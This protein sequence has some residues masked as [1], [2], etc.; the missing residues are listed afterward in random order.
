MGGWG[1][2]RLFIISLF[3]VQQTTNGI[4]TLY[5]VVQYFFRVDDQY[6]E[7]EK[8]QQT[9]FS[10]LLSLQLKKLR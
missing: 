6:A 10:V 2:A 1:A 9:T 4:S 3:P 8:Q 5:T 7:C